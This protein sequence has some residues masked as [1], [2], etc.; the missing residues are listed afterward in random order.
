MTPNPFIH[1]EYWIEQAD[2]KIISLDEQGKKLLHSCKDT[3][4]T[5][6]IRTEYM[7]AYIEAL[8]NRTAPFI[9]ITTSNND[10]AVPYLRYPDTDP[11]YKIS[12]DKLL[13]NEKLIRWYGR[14]PVIEHPK[15]I[16]LPAGP[17]WQWFSTEFYGE[18]ITDIL[19]VYT[20]HCL[21]PEKK[22]VDKE[23]K[24]N[25]LYLNY[26]VANTDE[27]YYKPHIGIR[28]EIKDTLA[29]HFDWIAPI[30]SR[31]RETRWKF[32]QYIKLLSTYKFCV[33]PPGNGNDAHR[34]WEALM[35]GV[36]PLLHK[37]GLQTEMYNNLPVVIVDDW[38]I[39]TP[40]YLQEVYSYM[41]NK[42]YDFSSL[43]T[44]YWDKQ[45]KKEKLLLK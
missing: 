45:I 3:P 41:H 38:N 4:V 13:N 39:I 29:Q 15:I 18:D 30:G 35:L 43:Y 8:N 37:E 9:L 17:K 36:I 31:R 10:H 14:L 40:A 24:S 11:Q 6:F 26:G 33:S 5:I 28:R 1:N 27:S 7:D 16:G 19:S 25:L 44:E 42:T 23:L 22:I 21:E 34:T 12:C 20:Q 2:T 32:D